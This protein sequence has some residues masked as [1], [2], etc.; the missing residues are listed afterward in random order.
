MFVSGVQKTDAERG[1]TV[2]E[3]LVSLVISG[4]MFAI[5][6]GMYMSVA[7][8]SHNHAV[9]IEAQVQAQA[10][11]QTMS[12]EV[13]VL[14][15]G[16]PFDQPNFQIGENTLSDVTKTYPVIL[17]SSDAST[18]AFR[19]NETGDVA[20]LTADYTP[21]GASLVISVT[22]A[23]AFQADDP[24][25]I[26][27]SVVSG[28]DGLYGEVASVSG[29]NVTIKAGYVASPG[30]TFAT[31]SIFEEVPIVTYTT[32]ANGITRDSGYGAVLLGNN[33]TLGIQY[34]DFNG[35]ALTPPLTESDLVNSLR[36][37]RLTVSVTSSSNLKNGEPY[38]ASVS[39]TVGL[40]N[41]TYV[42]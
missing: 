42:F 14:G 26:S 32:G 4:I 7:T 31:G 19:L 8:I 38:T 22:D 2:L 37:I 1:F 18:L 33:S 41:F 13:R 11:M 35:N 16:V 9:R 28:D 17:A 25:Y 21:S 10:I 20:L 29:N 40:R 27:N 12:G 24:I 5:L 23:S 6:M 34:L 36:S 39:Q 15:N 3:L 30:A